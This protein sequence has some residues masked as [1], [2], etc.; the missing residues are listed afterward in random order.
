MN[1]GRG[2]V[3]GGE[4]EGG[5]MEDIEAAEVSYIIGGKMIL[6]VKLPDDVCELV[7]I[8]EL[9]ESIVRI[10]KSVR[11]NFVFIFSSFVVILKSIEYANCKQQYYCTY[12]VGKSCICNKRLTG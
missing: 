7:F 8:S 5:E 11:N 9:I 6:T 1:E 4:E 3:Y 12:T 2:M 10:R